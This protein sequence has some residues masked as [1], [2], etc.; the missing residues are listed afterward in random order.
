MMLGYNYTHHLIMTNLFI[1]E[2]LDL[3]NESG[4]FDKDYDLAIC[5]LRQLVK[6]G[7]NAQIVFSP[8]GAGSVGISESDGGYYMEP[9][10]AEDNVAEVICLTLA[11]VLESD[12]WKQKRD[13]DAMVLAAYIHA[14]ADESTLPPNIRKIIDIYLD[15]QYSEL[16]NFNDDE[17]EIPF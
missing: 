13:G 14:H 2:G 1:H 11:Q 7:Y 16:P 17:D 15:S 5:A 10:D 12:D 8:T 9:F 4:R 6:H 3:P